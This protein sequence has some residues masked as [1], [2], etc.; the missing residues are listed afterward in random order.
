MKAADEILNNSAC[1]EDQ[2]LQDYA[3]HRLTGSELRRVE[4]H[5]AGCEMCSDMVE[6]MQSMKEND[7]KEEVHAIQ[8]RVSK[9]TQTRVI[10]IFPWKKIMSL[11][12][13]LVLILVVSR[14]FYVQMESGK[15]EKLA[16]KNESTASPK[17]ESEETAPTVVSEPT[18]QVDEIQQEPVKIVQ[19]QVQEKVSEDLPTSGSSLAPSTVEDDLVS[20][21]APE[22]KKEILEESRLTSTSIEGA[23]ARDNFLSGNPEQKK[24]EK[25][26]VFNTLSNTDAV[27]SESLSLNEVAVVSSNKRS[28]RKTKALEKSSA[29]QGV[30]FA[31][32]IAVPGKKVKAPYPKLHARV[33]LQ[34]MKDGNYKS[35]FEAARDLSQLE[36]ENDTAQFIMGYALV[37]LNRVEEAKVYLQKVADNANSPYDREALFELA[38]LKMKAGDESYKQT[39][40]ALAGGRDSTA[41]KARVYK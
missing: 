6:G 23:P 36:P 24:L 33:P 25:A 39:M 40:K 2:T 4:I 27:Q 20:S 21:P 18:E 8:Q 15:D 30:D 34:F 26:T 11:A 29:D 35:A 32:E 13:V 12:A 10:G 41:A 1:P 17:M 37:K 31:E 7:F 19:Q 22:S 3:Y 28:K 5:L 14:F 9:Q 38:L 16:L